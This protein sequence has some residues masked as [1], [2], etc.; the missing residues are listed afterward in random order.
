VT[1]HPKMEVWP[2][3]GSDFSPDGSQIVSILKDTTVRFLDPSSGDEVIPPLRGHNYLVRSTAFSPD[4]EQVVSESQD[5]TVPAWSV[6]SGVEAIPPVTDYVVRSIASSSDGTRILSGSHGSGIGVDN[7]WDRS[8]ATAV[9][10]TS[11][12][13]A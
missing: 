4:G 6:D 3:P 9:S 1:R 8:D 7:V 12:H 13:P 2:F 11:D 5:V 10:T